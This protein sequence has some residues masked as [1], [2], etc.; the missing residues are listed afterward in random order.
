MSIT[1]DA[2]ALV[3]D[4]FDGEFG[5]DISILKYTTSVASGPYRQRA[6]TYDPPVATRG[7]VARDLTADQLSAIGLKAPASG[8]IT[9]S[10]THLDLAFPSTPLRD[11]I[12]LQDRLGF[13]GQTWRVTETH[14]TGQ[15]GPDSDILLV[16]F[17]SLPGDE[18]APFP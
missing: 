10:R 18:E 8:S 12:G 5:D 2:R 17:D 15:F 9:F 7:H 6:R 14:P 13:D 11:A 3:H 4:L 1:T 16:G